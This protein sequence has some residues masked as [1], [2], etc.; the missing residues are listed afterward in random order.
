MVP[1]ANVWMSR[2]VGLDYAVDT[3]SRWFQEN[4]QGYSERALLIP[5]KG[6]LSS[7]GPALAQYISNGNTES[8]KGRSASSGGPVLAIGPTWGL[9]ETALGLADDHALGVIEHIPGANAGWAAAVGAIDLETGESTPDVPTQTREALVR[10]HDAGYNGY[11]HRE[12]YFRTQ[13][14][15][16]IETLRGN[17]YSFDFVASYLIAL[18]GGRAHSLEDLRKIYR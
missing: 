1:I 8:T 17:G 12:P 2:S 18:G 9:L 4:A 11:H 16:P 14:G 5:M 10:L 3:I 15:S 6:E 7:P 13:F